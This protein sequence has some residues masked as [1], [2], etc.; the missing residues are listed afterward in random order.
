[1]AA[2]P[3]IPH[4][5]TTQKDRGATVSKEG[6]RLCFRCAGPGWLNTI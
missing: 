4:F 6:F 1:M 2:Q 3:E 5:I